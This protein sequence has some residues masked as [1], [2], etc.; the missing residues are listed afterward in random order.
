VVRW[1]LLP[2]AQPVLIPPDDLAKRGPDFLDQEITERVPGGRL[3]CP[4]L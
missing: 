1:S 3:T 4:R 2:A